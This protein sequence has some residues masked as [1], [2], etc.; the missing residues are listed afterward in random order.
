MVLAIVFLCV[1]AVS[2]ANAAPAG[3]S[4]G[5]SAVV[6]KESVNLTPTPVTETPGVEEKK[7]VVD[8]TLPYPG[9]LTDHPL[10]F[11]KNLRDQIMERL[12]S[13]PS[14][15]AEFAILQSDKFLAMAMRFIDQGK[16][17]GANQTLESAE[18][19][20]EKAAAVVGSA[21]GNTIPNHIYEQLRL[22]SLKHE[23]VLENIMTNAP[24]GEKAAT[25]KRLQTGRDMVK[26]VGSL[27][28]Q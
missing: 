14:K 16:W 9:I 23:E 19:F 11:L 10:Y 8:Y 18:R 17:Q 24:V 12:I 2:A 27:N 4:P 3:V 21:T 5:K 7:E 13:D 20:M 28:K 15:K 25:E 1:S 6:K 22:S 26:R